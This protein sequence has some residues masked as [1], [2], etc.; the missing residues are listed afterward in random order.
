MKA[1]F[2][3][4]LPTT[5][6]FKVGSHHY[7]ERFAADGWDVLWVSHPISPLHLLHPVKRDMATRVRGWR[8][9]PVRDGL[10][11][12]YSPMT[13]LPTAALP[14]LRSGVVARWS[15]RATVPGLNRVLKQSGFGSP[16]LAWLT[17]PVFAPTAAALD[18]G[19]RV[20]RIADDTA[21]FRDSSP[22]LAALEAEAIAGAD[23][24]FAVSRAALERV[25]AV[26]EKVVRLPNGVD[27]ERFA[28][29]FSEPAEVMG[30]RRPR[31][32]YVG[33]VEYWFDLA[34]FSQC[35]RAN[36]AADF[37]VVGPDPRSMLSSA[38]M[39][40]NV[41]YLGARPY[42]QIPAIMQSCDVGI[43]PFVRDAMVDSIHPIKVY[44]YLAAGLK[45]VATRWTELEEMGAPVELAEPEGLPLAVTRALADPAEGRE[46][47]V[48]FAHANTWDARYDVV[49]KRV[50]ACMRKGGAEGGAQNT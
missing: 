11:R 6:A 48:R 42:D 50:A 27:A 40:A 15:G 25:A 30:F 13:L 14:L 24:V 4:S 10:M 8:E 32:L 22:A 33:A 19:C 18:A 26:N 39:P 5:S 43:I 44:E 23:L 35:A 9:G 1:V 31:V 16:D 36:P 12:Y 47:R 21:A 28:T 34:M 49:R 3:E 7:A 45:V 29:R 17:N 20:V 2:F 38:E 37:I 41:H 46:A